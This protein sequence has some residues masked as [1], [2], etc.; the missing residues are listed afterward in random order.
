MKKESKTFPAN[1]SGEFVD[2]PLLDRLNP[3]TPFHSKKFKPSEQAQLLIDK[4]EDTYGKKIHVLPTNESHMGSFSDQKTDPSAVGGYFISEGIGGSH[5]PFNRYVYLNPKGEKITVGLDKNT[6]YKPSRTFVLAHELG[7][8][9]DPDLKKSPYRGE[10]PSGIKRFAG[11]L[12][13]FLTDDR[14]DLDK[15]TYTYGKVP[16]FKSR[17]EAYEFFGKEALD[18]FK[19]EIN[20]Q[21]AAKDFF[22]ENKIND[23]DASGYKGPLDAYPST[24]L[25]G[26]DMGI[27]DPNYAQGIGF[28]NPI[29][30]EYANRSPDGSY[31]PGVRGLQKE[32]DADEDLKKVQKD[33]YDKARNYAKEKELYSGNR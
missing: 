24:Y 30:H 27:T 31:G 29:I 22:E 3:F 12:I 8:A 16:Q 23:A 17:A 14:T 25:H 26:Y 19:T 13:D 5:D 9:F 21:K 4:Y 20:A 1:F 6:V 33:L 28:N 18:K 11:G 2:R 10:I 32:I 7:H 15:R